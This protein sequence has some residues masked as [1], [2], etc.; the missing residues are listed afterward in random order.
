Q[1]VEQRRFADIRPA[2]N[3][4]D[5]NR[6]RSLVLDLVR[7]IRWADVML[8]L[9]EQQIHHPAA[10]DVFSGLAAMVQ[11]SAIVAAGLFEGIAEYRHA[12]EGALVVDGLGEGDDVCG[13]PG[14]IEGD[15][16]ERIAEDV[17]G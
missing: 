4:Y 3:R 9:A 17:A 11:D 8:T 14:W 5:R 12:L 15:G 2:D 10:A 13:A 6:H 16:A 7:S 1:P